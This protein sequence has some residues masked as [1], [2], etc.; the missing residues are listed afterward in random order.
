M[1]GC[2]RPGSRVW[3][4]RADNPRRKYPLTWE[5]VEA[6]EGVLVGIHSVR[7]NRLVREALEQ[8]ALAPFGR[9]TAIAAERR[10]EPAGEGAAVRVDF[11]LGLPGA[12]GECLVEVKSVTA[13][14]GPGQGFFPDAVSARAA[15]HLEA[16]AGAARAGRR[17]AL[18]YCVQ[19]DD[20]VRLRAAA[21]VDPGY[22][23]AL[24][25]ARAAGV[26][27]HAWRWRVTP[28]R[29]ELAGPVTLD[30]VVV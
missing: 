20:V 27:C 11:A 29:I 16:L 7:A 14:D 15:R 1:H 23:R 19:R 26:E 30:P 4:A 28:S 21:E 13:A 5:I 6:A 22:A 3:L 9:P 10:L 2:D 25:E 8:G 18:I 17:C 24:L 12:G